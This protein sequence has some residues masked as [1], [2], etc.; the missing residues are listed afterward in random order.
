MYA[1]RGLHR[2]ALAPLHQ[3]GSGSINLLRRHRDQPAVAE[4][5]QVV[6]AGAGLAVGRVGVDA[7]ARFDCDH[8]FAGITT[9]ADAGDA[10]LR[11]HAIELGDRRQRLEDRR[12]GVAGAAIQQSPVQSGFVV[13]A[14]ECLRCQ[15]APRCIRNHP[16]HQRGVGAQ[17]G[18]VTATRCECE[19]AVVGQGMQRQLQ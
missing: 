19:I 10:H 7:L 8:R 16:A 6:D 4:Q 1:V 13:I 2:V 11:Q 14:H 17:V 5:P 3:V 15:T 12:A 9:G 18:V